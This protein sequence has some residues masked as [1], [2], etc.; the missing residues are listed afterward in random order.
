MSDEPKLDAISDA[1]LDALEDYDLVSILEEI[2]G[3]FDDAHDTLTPEEQEIL[4][5][6]LLIAL[7]KPV[8]ASEQFDADDA[9]D[10]RGDS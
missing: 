7:E 2:K 4:D 6:G 1:I 5:D 10:K 8:K 3:V 9:A